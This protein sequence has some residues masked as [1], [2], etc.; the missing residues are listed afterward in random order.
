MAKTTKKKKLS[1]EQLDQKVLYFAYGSNMHQPRLEQ[2]VGPVKFI[3]TYSL[4]GYQLTFDT[5]MTSCT[6]ANVKECEK[7]TCEGVIFEMTYRQ[8]LVLDQYECLYRRFKVMYGERRL[9]LYISDYWRNERIV[10]HLTIEYYALLMLG[11]TEHNLRKSHSI[12]EK[13]KPSVGHVVITGQVF[14]RMEDEW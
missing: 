11:C 12:I 4:P 5:G 2:R 14:F 1:K 3:A 6:F 10:P 8:L 9:H 7:E 13:F